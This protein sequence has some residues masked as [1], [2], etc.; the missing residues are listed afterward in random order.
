MRKV[1]PLFSENDNV[2]SDSA[3][4]ISQAVLPASDQEKLQVIVSINH[5]CL[6]LWG[7][8]VLAEAFPLGT[9]ILLVTVVP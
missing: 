9:D 1:Q 6:A 2:I 3:V 8:A 7:T 4:E 5:F